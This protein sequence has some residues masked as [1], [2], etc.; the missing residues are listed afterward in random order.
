MPQGGGAQAVLPSAEEPHPVG[1]LAPQVE[2]EVNELL[3]RLESVPEDLAARKRLAL[4]YLGSDQYVPAFEQAGAVLAVQPDDIDS[5]YVQ[6]VVR[7]TMGQDDM[8][9]SQLDRV[10]ELFPEHA[11]ALTV[12]GLVFARRGER[13]RARAMWT[14]ALEVGGS[15][16]QIENL[17]SLL[18]AEEAGESPGSQASPPPAPAASSPVAPNE[19]RVIVEADVIPGFPQTGTLFVALRAAEGGP[20]LAVRRIDQPSFP[21]MISLGAQDM[22]MAGEAELPEVGFLTVRLDQDGSVGT[23]G[24]NDLEGSSRISKGSEITLSIE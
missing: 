21:M 13:A 6:G 7:M 12:K 17:L 2:G 19:Y 1:A 8:A 23:R 24:E 11:R 4:L 3:A 15:Q 14:R 16:P 22:M 5:L 20:P 18:D 10:L 9:L